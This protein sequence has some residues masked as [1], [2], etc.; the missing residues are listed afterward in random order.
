MIPLHSHLFCVSLGAAAVCGAIELDDLDPHILTFGQPGTIFGPC[1][2]IDASKYYRFQNTVFEQS[3]W[4]RLYDMV[5]FLNVQDSLGHTFLIGEDLAGMPHYGN[6]E[7]P[8]SFLLNLLTTDAHDIQKYI[9]RFQTYLSQST[10]PLQTNGWRE[11]FACNSDSE[12]VDWLHCVDRT[13]HSGL[14]GD[15]CNRDSD[16]DSGRCEGFASWVWSGTCEPRKDN[17]SWCDEDSDC[18]SNNCNWRWKCS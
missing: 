10:F 6:G 11:G 12:C 8:P 13:C 1:P 4:T 18:L 3:G 17:G 15:P 14:N 5:G 16:C 9:E 7:S 2:P